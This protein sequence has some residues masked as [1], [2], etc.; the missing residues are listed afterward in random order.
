MYGRTL[1]FNNLLIMLLYYG[2]GTTLNNKG[3]F[4][5]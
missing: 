1:F 5:I 3:A 4:V 2:M